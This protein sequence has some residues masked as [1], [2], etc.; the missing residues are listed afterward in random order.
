MRGD[1]GWVAAVVW[2]DVVLGNRPLPNPPHKGEGLTWRRPLW[3][4]AYT[5]TPVR[6]LDIVSFRS[7]RSCW[8]ER[9]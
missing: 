9:L 2:G 1:V 8:G 3:R 5:T 7:A 4:V 6:L